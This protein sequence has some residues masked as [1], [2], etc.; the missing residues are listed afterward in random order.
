[1]VRIRAALGERDEV[2]RTMAG[3]L[4]KVLGPKGRKGKAAPKN[5]ARAER[6]EA[7]GAKEAEDGD[8]FQS[9][10]DLEDAI[11]ASQGA[12][13]DRK[14]KTSE[15]A[16]PA[17]EAK[18]TRPAPPP[19]QARPAA[20]PPREMTPERKAL[21]DKA[22]AVQRTKQEDVFKNLDEKQKDK[23][24]AIAMKTFFKDADERLAKEKKG[25]K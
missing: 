18:P 13:E 21:L 3:F 17:E 10:A 6:N 22:M 12:M 20:P 1:M 25:K 2:T 9:L 19:Q 7:E 15:R 16:K 8:V 11:V 5:K 4:S 14:K 24:Y 23:L